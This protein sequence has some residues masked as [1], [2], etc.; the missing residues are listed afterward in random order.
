MSRVINILDCTIRDGS[1]VTHYNWGKELIRDVVSS[2]SQLNI[3]FIEIGNG[4]G[5]GA[6]RNIPSAMADVEYYASAIP[7]KGDSLIGSFFIPGIGNTD[8]LKFFRDSGGDFVRIGI[9]ATE[10]QKALSFIKEAKSLGFFVCCNLMKTYAV[11]KFSIVMNAQS[12]IDAGVDCIYIVD[13]A[14]GML[15]NQVVEYMLA[16][17]EFYSGV[18]LGF[19]G[20]NNLLMANANSLSAIENGA[21]F[22][23]ATL[24]GLG[25]G[26]GN[27]QL[28]SLVAILQKANLLDGQ[29]DVWKLSDLTKRVLE[30]YKLTKNSS[31]REITVGIANFHDSNTSMLERIALKYNVSPEELMVEVGRINIVNP[32]ED[33]FEFA[34]QKLLEGE[35]MKRFSPRYYHKKF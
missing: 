2:L 16:I 11:S 13:S 8:D 21:E 1:Y 26:A 34:A 6:F 10:S 35:T 15:P 25:R 27:A 3:H 20:H 32:S 12:I 22:A 31:K 7:V 30:K 19:H 33:L 4:T 28:E 9:N 18:K 29:Y 23:D 14:G 5:M 17:K 24:G